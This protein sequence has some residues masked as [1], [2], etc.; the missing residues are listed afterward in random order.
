MSRVVAASN[1]SKVASVDYGSLQ[2]VQ[3]GSV[4]GNQSSQSQALG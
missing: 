4:G 3:L 2:L 1:D